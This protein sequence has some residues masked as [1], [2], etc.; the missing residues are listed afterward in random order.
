MSDTITILPGTAAVRGKRHFINNRP[1]LIDIS[2]GARHFGIPREAVLIDQA[3]TDEYAEID[4]AL[5]QN[6]VGVVL[7]VLSYHLSIAPGGVL[8]DRISFCAVRR[9]DSVFVDVELE[10]LRSRNLN[11]ERLVLHKVAEH[12]SD[13]QPT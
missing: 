9:E 12:Q 11:G 3:L 5:G 10:V 1:K 2:R 6:L 8:H 7:S 13:F 4:T